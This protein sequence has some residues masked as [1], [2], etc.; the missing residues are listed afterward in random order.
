ML[1]STDRPS[2][3]TE[4]AGP[5]KCSPTSS[6]RGTRESGTKRAVAGFHVPIQ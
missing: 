5:V 3:V 2:G 1:K 6:S 4:P